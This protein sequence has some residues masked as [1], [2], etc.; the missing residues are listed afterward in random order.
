MTA[1]LT[2]YHP[3][4]QR[5][6]VA[7]DGESPTPPVDLTGPVALQRRAFL[8][9]TAIAGGRRGRVWLRPGRGCLFASRRAAANR[10]RIQLPAPAHPPAPVPAGADLEVKGLTPYVTANADFYRIDTALQVPII[11]AEAWRLTVTGLVEEE[12]TLTYAD[13]LAKPMVE[14]LSTLTCKANP[15]GANPIAGNLVG[16]AAWLGFPVRELLAQARPRAD[17]DMV[18]SVSVDGWSAGTPLNALLSGERQAL[19]AVGMNGQPLPA[20]H[21]F[22]VR[23]IVPGLY[24]DV[25]ATKWVTELKVTTFDAERATGL[26]GWWPADRSS[27]HPG[28]TFPAPPDDSRRARHRRRGGLRP[29][30]GIS[31]VEVRVDDKD[32]REANSPR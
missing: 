2:Q 14:H 20:E 1:D 10:A 13:L 6:D 7:A 16:N 28:S 29:H 15:V 30:I 21:G 31:A 8:R 26:V 32:W 18:L 17:A 24:G 22:P 27:C 3:S 11:E 25:S 12:V 5:A 9:T 4:R 23:M 19:L